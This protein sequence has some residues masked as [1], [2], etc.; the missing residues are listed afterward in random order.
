MS[1]ESSLNLDLIR[2]VQ[3]AR[4]QHDSGLRPSQVSATYWIE[5][6]RPSATPAPTPRT[7][8]FR[9]FTHV[10]QV[11]D[12]WERIKAATLAGQLGYKSKVSTRPTPDH[13]AADG[14]TIC[15]RTYDHSDAAD[16]ERVRAALVALGFTPSHYLTDHGE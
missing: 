15:V 12:D 1:D 4:M 11:D 6:K 16:V 5:C 8:E 13:P 3:Q 9:L 14:R 7:G 2:M 10:A